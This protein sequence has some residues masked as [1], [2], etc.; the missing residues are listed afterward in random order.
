MVQV[1]G[2]LLKLW[3]RWTDG[4]GVD[5]IL[6]AKDWNRRRALVNTVMNTGIP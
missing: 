3:R 6:L 1:D 4:E 2:S 5:W